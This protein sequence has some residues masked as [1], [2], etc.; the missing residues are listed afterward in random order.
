MLKARQVFRKRLW[1]ILSRSNASEGNEICV[2]IKLKLSKIFQHT[3]LLLENSLKIFRSLNMGWSIA[4]IT[5]VISRWERRNQTSSMAACHLTI[6]TSSQLITR[7][8][9]AS[10][11]TKY[12]LIGAPCCYV[13]A[14]ISCL[15]QTYLCDSLYRGAK[16]HRG[17]VIVQVYLIYVSLII[18]TVLISFINLM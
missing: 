15:R 16:N 1:Q 10:N 2:N 3:V 12:F 13:N 17:R 6:Y 18:Q 14:A 8:F 5:V 9:Y 7:I 4:V 11:S